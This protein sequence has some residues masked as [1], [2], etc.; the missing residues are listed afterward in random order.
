MTDS[1]WTAKT[2]KDL[3]VASRWSAIAV[4]ICDKCIEYFLETQRSKEFQDQ[5]VFDETLT[6]V[7]ESLH[8]FELFISGRP[9]VLNGS[10]CQADLDMG[11]ALD[12]VALRL[13]VNLSESYPETFRYLNNLKKRSSFQK[14]QPPLPIV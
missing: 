5:S 12:Y 1:N 8:A 6:L 2:D 13:S 9:T 3:I 10:L 7:K 11:A 4:G 14:T